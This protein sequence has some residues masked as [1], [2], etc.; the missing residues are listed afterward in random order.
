[1]KALL[2][3]GMSVC[4]FRYVFK[5]S[6]DTGSDK[7]LIFDRKVGGVIETGND[8]RWSGMAVIGSSH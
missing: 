7:C 2:P 8:R 6:C 4:H 5:R 1:M 3:E